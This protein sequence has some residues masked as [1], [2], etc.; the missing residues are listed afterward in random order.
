M[1]SLNWFLTNSGLKNIK[2][3]TGEQHLEAPI[4]SVNVL[5]NP[6]VIK[7]FKRDELILT[8]GFVFKEHPELIAASIQSL[9]ET[10]C[11]AL[12]I[13][14][15]RFFR[16]VP[17]SLL[18]IARDY[19]F[20]ILELPYFY[21]FSEIMQCIFHQIDVESFA[22]QQRAQ[23]ILNQLLHA[24][25]AHT[26]IARLLE[27]TAAQLDT[28]VIFF[29]A[30]GN[31]HAVGLPQTDPLLTARFLAASEQHSREAP[32][33]DTVLQFQEEQYQLLPYA[34]P[35]QC[36]TLCLAIPQD[37]GAR[38]A[39]DFMHSITQ[40][41]A[42]AY[43]QLQLSD[44]RYESQISGFLQVLLYP[45]D[46]SPA[47][48]RELCLFYAFPYQ[49]AWICLTIATKELPARHK[50]EILHIIRSILK[51]SL[52]SSHNIRPYADENLFCCFFIF[53]RGCH[54]LSAIKEVEAIAAALLLRLQHITNASLPAGC[55]TLHQGLAG[56]RLAFE[57][58]L[59][60]ALAPPQASAATPGSYLSLLPL[61]MVSSLAPQDRQLLI[62]N[63]LQPLL[64]YDDMHQTNLRDTLRIYLQNNGN[65]SATAKAL[66]LHRN[67]MIHRINK[68]KDILQLTLED[69]QETLMLQ[70]AL[71]AQH[72]EEHR[73]IP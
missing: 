62:H 48:L 25:L 44:Q 27:L 6:D 21:G 17:E 67:T 66:F 23:D 10:G 31:V 28:P 45:Q 47:T 38:P 2:L 70:L 33:H 9:K 63:L 19:D 32:H 26:P 18:Q 65:I 53:P 16:T 30:Q 71:L 24:V 29:N 59:Q 41:F 12:A 42:L 14:I 51:E 46:C 57:E 72:W 61:Q 49:K 20:P 13:K 40:F 37:R 5:D 43:E 56:I 34:L 22:S 50:S 3:L 1:P 55:S 73:S 54:A 58:S 8:T 4:L 36:G 39:P 60:A 69:S 52:A 15:P 64:Q 7:W 11:C 35:N 68:I